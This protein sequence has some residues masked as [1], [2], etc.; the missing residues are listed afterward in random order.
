MDPIL[1]TALSV[2]IPAVV[3]STLAPMALAWMQGRNAAKQRIDEANVRGVEKRADYERQDVVAKRL[4]ESNRVV[5]EAIVENSKITNTKLDEVHALVN[6]SYTAALQATFE[7]V[8]AKL[9]VLLDSIEF[10]KEHGIKIEQ[11][12]VIDIEATKTKMNELAAAV[13]ERLKQD[14]IA[15]EEKAKM[16]L[17]GIQQKAAI[18][19]SAVASPLPVT[20][21]RTA[22]ASERVADAAE[23]SADATSR[24]ADAA[25]TMKK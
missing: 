10:K 21:E 11:D 24:V 22:I 14:A 20:D 3:A 25:E 7:A 2:A 23:R 16:I 5:A 17:A 1:I 15:K 8:Q 18:A 19:P 4:V 9:V 6:S 12:V 13:T